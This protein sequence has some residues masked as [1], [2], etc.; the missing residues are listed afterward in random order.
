MVRALWGAAAL[1]L[2]G[3]GCAG[4]PSRPAGAGNCV[5]FHLD[6]QK[7]W[8]AEAK[9]SLEARFRAAGEGTL[10]VTIATKMDAATRSWVMMNQ[11]SRR[12]F[13]C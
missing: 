8:N 1:A 2:L 5:D 4:A 12:I 7:F 13:I 9:A 6:V 10:G 11:L 3:M